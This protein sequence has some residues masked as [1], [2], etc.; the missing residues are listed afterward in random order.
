MRPDD[1]AM[2]GMG[3]IALKTTVVRPDD[4]ATRGPGS[5]PSATFV[6]PPAAG[7]FDWADAGVGAAAVVGLGLIG[8]G[9]FVIVARNRRGPAFS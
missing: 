9:A 2:H 6:E 3:A 8:F 5:L 4:R 7:A 1:Q